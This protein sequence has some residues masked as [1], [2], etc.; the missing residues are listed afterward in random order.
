MGEPFSD[1][2]RRAIRQSGLSHYAICQ[3][4]GINKAALSRFVNGKLGLS[5]DSIDKIV[6]FLRLKLVVEPFRKRK[7]TGN[8]TALNDP[9]PLDPNLL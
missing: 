9:T 4:T 7:K 5:L 3:A 1:Q 2:L 8:R 6:V